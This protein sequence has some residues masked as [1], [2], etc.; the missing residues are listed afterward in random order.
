M[1][2]KYIKEAFDTN[3]VVPLGPNVN[4]FEADLEKLVGEGKRVVALSSGTAAVHLGLLA[5]GDPVR[6]CRCIRGRGNWPGRRRGCWRL[7]WRRGISAITGTRAIMRSIP[8]SFTRRF[9]FGG[10]LRT[11]YG[12]VNGDVNSLRGALKEIYL[13][14]LGNPGI[15]IGQVAE[16]R[17]KSES[18]VWKQLN[19]L[20][21][22]NLIEYRDSDKTGGYYVKK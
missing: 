17:K 7:L 9:L 20:K 15:K 10:I 11:V 21:R 13:I 5:A 14:V 6:R 1:E 22:M 2:Q 4:G 3:W 18:T 19:E 16:I 12:D 8:W